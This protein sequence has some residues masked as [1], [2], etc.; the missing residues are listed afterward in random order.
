MAVS[1]GS[2]IASSMGRSVIAMAGVPTDNLGPTPML[3]VTFPDDQ[4]L[5]SAWNA[6]GKDSRQ[7]RAL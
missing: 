5:R 2:E 4:I 3:V 6:V 7:S 1:S